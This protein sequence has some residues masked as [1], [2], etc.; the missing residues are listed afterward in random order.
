[1]LLRYLTGGAP[2][3]R[4]ER[5]ATSGA[6]MTPREMQ[7]A[8]QVSE[9][10]RRR[11]DELTRA[12]QPGDRLVVSELSWLG[13][14]LGQVVA[15]SSMRSPRGAS[16]SW[17]TSASR[18]SATSRP[19]SM[20]TLFAL[21]AE[22]ERALISERAREGLTKARAS[23]RKQSRNRCGVPSKSGTRDAGP[24]AT[25]S[26]ALPPRRLPPGQHPPFGERFGAPG[27]FPAG[28]SA[29]GGGAH[30]IAPKASLVPGVR[31]DDGRPDRCW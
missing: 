28:S 23:R 17:R 8:G 7:A 13:W 11:L 26:D 2:T 5:G 9:E 20:I 1:M 27:R 16:P 3:D 4:S 12:L 21:L 10:C 19:R 14:S 18:A 15:P 31:M 29:A 30:D 25:V 22:G 24:R 6:P